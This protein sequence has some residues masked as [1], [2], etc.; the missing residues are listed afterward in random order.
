MFGLP[1]KPLL[2]LLSPG[3]RRGRLSILIYH[4]VLARDDPF[5]PWGIGA[6][7]FT[8]QMAALRNHFN[9]I[10]L[11]EAIARLR[12]MSLSPSRKSSC[13]SWT[14][15]VVCTSTGTS[16][17]SRWRCLPTNTYGDWQSPD[18]W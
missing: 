2:S 12:S 16:W 18:D 17:P 14:K 7:G 3:G 5:A 10:P 6:E 11:S 13:P 4:R 1:M 9:V 8:A 15:Q